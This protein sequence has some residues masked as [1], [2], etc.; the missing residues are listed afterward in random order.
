MGEKLN[1]M[2]QMK[3]VEWTHHREAHQEYCLRYHATLRIVRQT[4][5]GN[6]ENEAQ[7]DTSD[8]SAR[9][10]VSSETETSGGP[11]DV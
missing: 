2:W 5:V 4:E 9:T 1:E 11:D 6:D 10:D 3:A 7:R 8:N